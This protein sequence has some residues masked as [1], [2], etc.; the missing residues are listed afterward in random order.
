MHEESKEISWLSVQAKKQFSANDQH[1]GKG[2]PYEK[3][4]AQGQHWFT[5]A[6]F[7]ELSVKMDITSLSFKR[8][9]LDPKFFEHPDLKVLNMP[10]GEISRF[11]LPNLAPKMYGD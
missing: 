9:W 4:I 7:G 8:E 11:Y 10:P 5:D 1:N 6:D 2:S 3:L